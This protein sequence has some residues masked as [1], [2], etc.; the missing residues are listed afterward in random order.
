MSCYAAEDVDVQITS[1]GITIPAVVPQ[2][3]LQTSSVEMIFRLDGIS[4][5]A[6]ET[7]SLGFQFQEGI[8]GPNP[9]LQDALQG[10]VVDANSKNNK[11][12]ITM[13]HWCIY[14][15]LCLL[16]T[17]VTFQLSESD[18]IQREGSNA[19][20]PVVITKASDVFIA[21]PVTFLVIPLTVDQALDQQ[22]INSFEPLNSFSPNRAG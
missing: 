5:E 22:V 7:F 15:L 18:Y 8:F 13:V 2:V 19:M 11:N 20:M 3:D 21:N 14:I 16:Y 12:D 10:T 9:T 1:P 4:Q 17:A 6:N